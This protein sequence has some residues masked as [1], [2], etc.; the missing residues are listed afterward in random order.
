MEKYSLLNAIILVVHAKI[1][2]YMANAILAK[3]KVSLICLVANAKK[4]SHL[5]EMFVV[6][7]KK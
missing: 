7:G 6:R 4:N 2:N 5:K 1:K 3:I